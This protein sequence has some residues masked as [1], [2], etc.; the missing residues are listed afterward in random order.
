[1]HEI[2]HGDVLPHVYILMANKTEESYNKL[3]S[4][5]KAL[6]PILTPNTIIVD[7]ERAAIN[8]FRT[9]F[10]NSVQRGCFFIFHNV[11]FDLFNPIICNSCT[12]V[13]LNLP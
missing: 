8:A 5:L 11:Y 6:E 10:P 2:V 7:V 1:M 13:M 3:L 9:V 4:E 12:R